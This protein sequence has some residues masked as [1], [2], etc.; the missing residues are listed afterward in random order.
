MFK[1]IK[2][3]LIEELKNCPLSKKE[4]AERV[5]VS[6]EMITQYVTT[7]KLPKLDTFAKICKELDLSALYILGLEEK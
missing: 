4:M 5:G 3:R 7:E 2:E 1:L 6:P